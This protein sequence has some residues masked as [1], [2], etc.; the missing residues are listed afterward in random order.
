MIFPGFV[1]TLCPHIGAAQNADDSYDPN[2]NGNVRV[3]AV[4][5]N[6]KM[7]VGGSF[8]SIGGQARDRIGGL[9]A[10][11]SLNACSGLLGNNAV[12]ALHV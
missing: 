12:N 11:G 9:N 2:A 7:L 10:D 6:G 4:Q 3:L 8:S 1:M 5:A